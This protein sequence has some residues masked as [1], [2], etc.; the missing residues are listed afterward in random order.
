MAETALDF[1]Q[2]CGGYDTIQTYFI[3]TDNKKKVL[4]HTCEKCCNKYQSETEIIKAYI[5]KNKEVVG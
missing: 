4:F 5:N 3:F 1:C 2:L